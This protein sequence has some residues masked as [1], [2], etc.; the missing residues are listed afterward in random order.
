M[1][2]IEFV[3]NFISLYL[4]TSTGGVMKKAK[5]QQKLNF[6]NEYRI[7]SSKKGGYVLLITP[8]GECFTISA[9]KILRQALISLSIK[10]REDQQK[11]A[12]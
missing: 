9:L 5:K 8:E 11:E 4:Q 10:E 7:F 6:R 1:P 3:V 2:F 12:A